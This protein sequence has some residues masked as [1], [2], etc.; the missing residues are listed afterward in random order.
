MYCTQNVHSGAESLITFILGETDSTSEHVDWP[1]IFLLNYNIEVIIST[2]FKCTIQWFFSSINIFQPPPPANDRTQ[3]ESVK[4]TP[5]SLNH[6]SHLI[7]SQL[8]SHTNL[9]SVS[10]DTAS[11][12]VDLGVWL[13]EAS[14]WSPASKFHPCHSMNQYFIAF[15][16][17]VIFHCIHISHL[18]IHSSVMGL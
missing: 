12:C 10:M 13:L 2:T 8:L 1:Y 17:W 18:I 5:H 11:K 14:F 6:H 16:G 15:Y 7:F 4:E 3:S 9:L